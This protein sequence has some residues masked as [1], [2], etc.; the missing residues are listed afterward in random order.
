MVD[1]NYL[2]EIKKALRDEAIKCTDD[3]KTR[4]LII[5]SAK[6][7]KAIPELKIIVDW[8]ENKYKRRDENDKERKIN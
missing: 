6:L 8:Y 4:T 2:K 7:K 5:L 1:F 3:D